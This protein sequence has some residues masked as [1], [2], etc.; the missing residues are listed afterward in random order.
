MSDTLESL[1]SASVPARLKLQSLNETMPWFSTPE[2]LLDRLPGPD[3]V[4]VTEE[5][6]L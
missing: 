6:S 1:P 2:Q 3:E 4:K 5:A